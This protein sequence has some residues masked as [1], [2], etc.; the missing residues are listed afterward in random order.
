MDREEMKVGPKGQ[1]VIPNAM[2]RALKITP[3]SKVYITQENG[4]VIIEKPALS[5]V[6]TFEKISLAGSS[7]KEIDPHQYEEE[8]EERTRR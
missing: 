1:I 4:K 2:R 6:D 5:S 7:I 8:I 3:G